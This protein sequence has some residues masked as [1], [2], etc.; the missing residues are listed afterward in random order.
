MLALGGRNYQQL[1]TV[2]PGVTNLSAANSMGTGGFLNSKAVS[3]NGMGR[4]SVFY[5]LDGI[6]NQELGDLLTNAR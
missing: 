4:T 1:S 5:T 6:W 2:M 3:V